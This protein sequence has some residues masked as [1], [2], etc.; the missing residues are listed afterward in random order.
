M[1]SITDFIYNLPM[2]MAKGMI[3]VVLAV[4]IVTI[5]GVLI[6]FLS[7]ILRRGK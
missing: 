4:I 2:S 3:T 6:I 1:V 5:V 7:E